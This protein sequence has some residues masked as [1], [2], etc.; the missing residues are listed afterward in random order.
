MTRRTSSLR[1]QQKRGRRNNRASGALLLLVLLSV[2]LGLNYTVALLKSPPEYTA[3]SRVSFREAGRAGQKETGEIAALVRSREVLEQVLRECDPPWHPPKG[4]SFS[5]KDPV[6]ALR[7]QL[8]VEWSP[9]ADII[10]ISYR[11]RDRFQA[12]AVAN[13]LAE[14]VSAL[15]NAKSLH[16]AAYKTV[17]ENRLE[18]VEEDIA[19]LER[20]KESHDLFHSITDPQEILRWVSLRIVELNGKIIRLDFE[21]DFL[22]K[23]GTMGGQRA[24]EKKQLRRILRQNLGILE[25]TGRHP[26][27]G[28]VAAEEI[29]KQFREVEISLELRHAVKLALEQEYEAL[30]LCE[31]QQRPVS[32]ILETA[33]VPRRQPFLIRGPVFRALR[34]S[35]SFLRD[36]VV[37][38]EE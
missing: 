20:E 9:D 7:E 28:T 1:M 31:T 27:P 18:E 29:K 36:S 3:A 21:I 15:L 8:S 22:M 11:D 25:R 16:S 26:L 5:R 14:V 38:L 24:L 37:C 35:A 23:D 17:I 33:P 10:T 19:L 32:R 2:T 30:R 4:S 13:G 34:R 6:A 12:A